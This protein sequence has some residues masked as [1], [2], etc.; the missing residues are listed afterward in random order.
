MYYFYVLY[1]LKD[2]QLYKGYTSEIAQRLQRHQAGKVTAT[3]YRRPLVLIHLE[4]FDN[5]TDA[6]RREKEAKQADSAVALKAKFQKKG[7]LNKEYK[8]NFTNP[9]QA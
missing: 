9:T 8:L 3:K 7:I 4:N 6:M 2:H 1:S 5:R